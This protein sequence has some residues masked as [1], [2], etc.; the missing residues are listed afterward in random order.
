MLRKIAIASVAVVAG[1]FILNST[2]LGSYAKTAFHK[3]RSAAKEQIGI[4]FQLDAIKHEVAELIPDMQQQAR[5]IAV[6]KVEVQS[7]REQIADIRNNFEKQRDHVKV[8]NTALKGGERRVSYN[9]VEMPAEKLQ[10]RLDRDLAACKRC[11]EELKAKEQLLEAEEAQLEAAREQ[12]AGMKSQKEQL[13][14]QVAQLEAELKTL[15]VAQNRSNFQLDDSRLSRIKAS[16]A[17]V[18]NQMRVEQTTADM[19][20][21]FQN[22]DFPTSKQP[23]SKAQLTKEADEFLNDN[24]EAGVAKK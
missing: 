15:R 17:D 8:M 10:A 23:K 4:E 12:W 14:V 7:L 5:S 22:D 9:G 2:H 24:G 20:A 13:E 21:A 6:K 19:V 18:R 3:I 11:A 16:L 1:L